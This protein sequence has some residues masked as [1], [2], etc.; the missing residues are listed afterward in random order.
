MIALGAMV[1]WFVTITWKKWF[2]WGFLIAVFLACWTGFVD[3]WTFPAMSWSATAT[4]C[5]CIWT[6][7][8][9]KTAFGEA[10]RRKIE[11]TRYWEP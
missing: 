4:L 11:T 7:K 8:S 10:F 5:F 2:G 6:K 3:H 9:S 1:V